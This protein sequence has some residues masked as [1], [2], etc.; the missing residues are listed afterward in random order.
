MK[1]PVQFEGLGPSGLARRFADA[2]PVDVE[3][4]DRARAVL[5]EASKRVGAEYLPPREPLLMQDRHVEAI[6]AAQAALMDKRSTVESERDLPVEDERA[7]EALAAVREE[8]G[9]KAKGGRPAKHSG[10][11]WEAEGISRALWYR[12]R[13]GAK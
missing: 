10:K 3:R 8:M 5:S 1:Q 4:L 7:R 11:P 12:R 2:D 13:K 9:S 6:K